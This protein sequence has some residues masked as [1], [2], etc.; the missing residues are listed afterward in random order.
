VGEGA[1]FVRRGHISS[2]RLTALCEGVKIVSEPWASMRRVTESAADLSYES[3]F[4]YF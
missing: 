2:P 4:N 3:S 1:V